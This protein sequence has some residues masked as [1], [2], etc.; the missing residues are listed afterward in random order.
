[1]AVQFGVARETLSRRI[2]RI[3][4]HVQQNRADMALTGKSAT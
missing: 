2:S 3:R 4:R 1:L